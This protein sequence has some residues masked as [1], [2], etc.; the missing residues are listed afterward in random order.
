MGTP[1]ASLPAKSGLGR[2]LRVLQPIIWWCAFVL[3]LIAY[4]THKQLS[5]RTRLLFAI[6]LAGRE[7]W[8]DATARIDGRDTQS[9]QRI[10]VGWHTLTISHA[11][12]EPFTTNLFIWYGEH[13]LG[14]IDLARAQGVLE[15]HADPPAQTLSIRGPE[16][17]K[18][19]TNCG[20]TTISLP[21][22]AY[23]IEAAYAHLPKHGEVTI[24]HG[25]VTPYWIAPPLGALAISSS[26]D[27]ATFDLRTDDNR[28]VASDW[29][30]ATVAE[31]PAGSY[32]L[33]SRHL[34]HTRSES[35]TVKAGITNSVRVELAY[36]NVVLTTEPSGAT[37]FTDDGHEW[38]T[39]PL[40]LAEVPV[41]VW[42]FTLRQNGY[43]PARISLEISANQT[44]VFRTNL[45]SRTAR[46]P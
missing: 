40:S 2:W 36:G 15:L 38:G 6:S 20:G 32:K 25:V 34:L 19:W 5:E 17:R 46:A 23:T 14:R 27:G 28:L 44:A 11:Q 4:Q 1:S 26:E 16:F 42:N 8:T 9:G 43:E 33:V 12:A 10:S 7:T 21:T 30:P 41:G 13:K 22:D 45:V 18:T 39:T 37:V 35:V 29:L 31:L 24:K 3:V